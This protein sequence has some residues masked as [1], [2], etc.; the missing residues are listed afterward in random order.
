MAYVKTTWITGS[1][2]L[3]ATNMNHIEKGIADAHEMIAAVANT[4]YPVGCYF[5]TSDA[6]FNPNGVFSG[7]WILE[8]QGQVHVSAG[9][10][11]PVSGALLNR[12]DGGNKDLVIPYH[13]HAIP[14]LSGTAA[15]NGAHSHS[16]SASTGSAGGHTHLMKSRKD[17][18]GSGKLDSVMGYSWTG[19]S[20]TTATSSAGAHTHTVSAS[21]A[22]A[23][24]HEHSVT[25]TANN[26]GTVG[27]SGNTTN[28]NM[29]PYINVYRWHRTA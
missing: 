10:S 24:A 9:G 8:T 22:S 18:Y 5:E 28:A 21:C 7:T 3:S 11:Y 27:S 20:N 15:S 25:T 16:I 19:G 23:G 12:T 17:A 29:M 6:N 13:S 26:T 14:A 1:T 2:P 4:I